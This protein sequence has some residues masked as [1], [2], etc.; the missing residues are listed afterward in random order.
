ME[1]IEAKSIVHRVYNGKYWF[2]NDYNMNIY[3]G[4]NHGCIYCDSR[5]TC[6]R[7]EEFDTV[8]IKKE[9]LNIIEKDLKAKRLRGIIGTGAMS[10]PYNSF[11]KKYKLTRN[12][13]SLVQEYGFGI[14]ICTK[15]SLVTRDIDILSKIRLKAN[16]SVNITITDIDDKRCSKI[17]KTVDVTSKRFEAMKEIS[18][19]GIYTGTLMMPIMPFINDTWE[20][21]EGIILATKKAGG[22]FIYPSFGLTMRDGQREFLYSNLDK[23]FPGIRKIYEKTYKDRYQCISPNKDELYSKFSKLCKKLNIEFEMKE[24]IK[25][26]K[27]TRIE[28]QMTIF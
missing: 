7:N 20:N 22:K 18:E 17:E 21:I 4:C 2:G 25:N 13:L 8:K 26:I 14:G 3:R 27:K 9:A 12:A 23:E 10:D 28:K 24:I 5:S 15:S 19:N 11:E 6:Y 16:V 1:V